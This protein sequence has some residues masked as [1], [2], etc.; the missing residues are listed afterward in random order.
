MAMETALMGLGLTWSIERLLEFL[1]SH[2]PHY[3]T[4]GLWY[5][6]HRSYASQM[7]GSATLRKVAL[8]I[9]W[10]MCPAGCA[11]LRL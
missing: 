10:K 5:S 7:E 11:I 1:A 8:D 2:D 3:R 4:M 6:I 9:D